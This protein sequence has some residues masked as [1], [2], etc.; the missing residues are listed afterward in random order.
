MDANHGTT[1]SELEAHLIQT[2]LRLVE[3]IG[4]L[5]TSKSQ[6]A[7]A[8][9][10]LKDLDKDPPVK[11]SNLIPICT[12]F[13]SVSSAAKSTHIKETAAAAEATCLGASFTIA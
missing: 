6:G 13:T 10:K 5:S 4:V 9:L 3:A 7:R 2:D 8:N 12:S 1:I 11:F